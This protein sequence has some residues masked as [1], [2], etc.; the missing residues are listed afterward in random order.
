M[1]WRSASP[2]PASFTQRDDARRR[3]CYRFATW[4]DLTRP[5]CS[6]ARPIR[7]QEQRA[8]WLQTRKRSEKPTAVYLIASLSLAHQITQPDR[9]PWR[10][11]LLFH[12]VVAASVMGLYRVYSR[13]VFDWTVS[14]TA[15]QFHAA[16][17][18]V[19]VGRTFLYSLRMQTQTINLSG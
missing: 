4:L 16:L 1:S 2:E 11:F 17:L 10:I 9:V 18:S 19:N 3:V 15:R 14:R 12:G 7:A 6:D 5:T 13:N 8:H